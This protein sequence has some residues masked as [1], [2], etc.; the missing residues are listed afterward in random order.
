[1]GRMLERFSIGV[2]DRFGHQCGAQLR[3][4][5][6]AEQAGVSI[7]PVWNK[8][9]RE[10]SLIGTKP[11]MTRTAAEEAVRSSGWKGPY[12]V[13][14]DH[15][16]LKN[17][18]LFLE[19]CDFFTIDVADSI[20]QHADEHSVE[21]FGRRWSG[22]K[23]KLNVPGVPESFD[24]TDVVLREIALKYLKAVQEAGEIYR[25]IASKKEEGSFVVEVS[26]DETMQP[27]SPLEMLFILSAIAEEK[28]PIQTIAPKFSGKFLKGIDYVGSVQQFATEFEADVHV[29]KYAIDQFGLP[30]NVKLSVH[31]GSDKFSLYPVIHSILEKTNAGVH[32]KTAGTTWLE[33]LIGLA[34]AGGKGLAMAKAIYSQALARM[35]ELTKPY[36]T[37]VEIDK[38]KLP[39]A[40]ELTGWNSEQYCNALR[41]IPSNPHYNLHLRQ[42]L[43][44][45]FKVAAELGPRY[46]EMLVKYEDVVASNVTENLYERHI[47][48]LFL[49]GTRKK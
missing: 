37:V 49:G 34:A 21:A 39:S 3:A 48:P 36:A 42:M 29:V 12:F 35:E 17:V 7:T 46:T 43:H 8:S 45:A 18:D 44:V 13:D 33:E 40:D 41:H 20:G 1:M 32:L 47:V 22:M 38:T 23:G 28:I 6:I 10:H 25:H 5:Q 19:A 24:V 31:S 2:G 4:L 15:V 27:Q 14:A 9:Y 16:G 11:E 30:K 26:M